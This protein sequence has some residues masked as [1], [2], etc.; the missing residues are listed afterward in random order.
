MSA[1]QKNYVANGEVLPSPP[2][3]V[4]IRKFFEYVFI[5]VMLYIT[6]LFSL[7]SYA[8]A[9]GSP[10]RVS[11]SEFLPGRRPTQPIPRPGGYR[12]EGTGDRPRRIRTVDDNTS[13]NLGL[14]YGGC[15]GGGCG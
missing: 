12:A 14:K 10:Y 1:E 8:A 7:D 11:N 9:R 15:C 6:T 3:A 13:V 4:S 2:L 5:F